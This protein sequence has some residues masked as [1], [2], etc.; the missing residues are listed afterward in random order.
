MTARAIDKVRRLEG[1]ASALPQ[2]PIRTDHVLHAGMYARTVFVPAG[3]MITGVEI[4]IP[5]LLIIDGEAIVYADDKPMRLSGHNVL[6]CQAP[7]KQAFVAETDLRLTM[8]FPTAATTI[9]EAERQFSDEAHLLLS[10][11]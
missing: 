6:S 10:R 11:R 5:T 4:K 2:V 1:L 3:V 7:R 9:E 8:V